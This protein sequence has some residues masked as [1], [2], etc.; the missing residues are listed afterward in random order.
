MT[1]KSTHGGKRRNAGRPIE[2]RGAVTHRCVVS[3]TDRDLTLL[4]IMSNHGNRSRAMRE[5]IERAYEAWLDIPFKS[6]PSD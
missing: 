6:Q 2:S 5:A 4:G 3:L 1:T